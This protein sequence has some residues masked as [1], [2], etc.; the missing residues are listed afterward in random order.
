M[1]KTN[2]DTSN[3]IENHPVF[4]AFYGELHTEIFYYIAKY[5][6]SFTKA[7]EVMGR[8]GLKFANRLTDKFKKGE[9][10]K[11]GLYAVVTNE[12]M[13][14][15]RREKRHQMLSLNNFPTNKKASTQEGFREYNPNYEQEDQTTNTPL[16]IILK[17]EQRRKIK[18]KISNLKDIF[19]EV[20]RLY[21]YK[22]MTQTEIATTLNIPEGT[23]K[24]RLNN[25]RKKIKKALQK[26]SDLEEYLQT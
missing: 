3:E 1:I 13:D 20:I 7:E 11:P 9:R 8:I 4:Q 26:E 15:Q 16:E 10:I 6:K 25:A 24:S 22:N 23:V 21:Y 12:C 18:R 19:R 2:T 5:L 14:Y 17:K